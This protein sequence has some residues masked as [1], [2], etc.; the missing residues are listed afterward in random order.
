MC[1]C[2]CSGSEL[3]HAHPNI[4]VVL[5]ANGDPNKVELLDAMRS[6]YGGSSRSMRFLDIKD[7]FVCVAALDD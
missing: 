4:K 3:T 1:N 7:R 5:S 2:Q 6:L